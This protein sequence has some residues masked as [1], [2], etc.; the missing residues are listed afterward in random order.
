MTQGVNYNSTICLFG[1]FKYLSGRGFR[2]YLV[3][4]VLAGA[5]E[6]LRRNL[7]LHFAKRQ[8]RLQVQV[9][10]RV[11]SNLAYPAHGVIS[12]MR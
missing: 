11:F 8:Y 7:L 12:P 9:S 2:G 4:W 5:R 10:L 3:S 6:L 1:F